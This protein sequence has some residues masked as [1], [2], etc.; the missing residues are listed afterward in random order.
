M[1]HLH[2]PRFLTLCSLLSNR[3]RDQISRYLTTL[4]ARNYATGSLKAVVTVLIRF[5]HALPPQRFICL[6]Q[7]FAQV[8]PADLD[9]LLVSAKANHLAPST[10]NNSVTLLRGFFEFLRDTGE[11]SR[12]PII[13]HRHPVFEPTTLPKPM[14]E[15]DLVAFFKAI[16]EVRDRSIFLL[17]LRCGLRI[18]E[19]CA[20]TW[21]VVDFSQGTLLIINGKGQVD[22]TAYLAPDVEQALRLWQHAQQPQSR[23]LFPGQYPQT[24][25][26]SCKSVS[27]RMAKYLREANVTRHYSPHCLRH[28]FA[29]QLINAGVTL[30]ALKELLGH[31]SLQ[32]TLCYTQLYEST[33]RQQYDQAMAQIERRQFGLGR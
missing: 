19:V 24:A 7:N 3:S 17:M 20:L 27:R 26:L 14:A 33:K 16:D 15:A 32:M 1:V 10:I 29:T 2:F 6:K 21:P 13:R 25:P 11:L 22:R 12:Q 18:S 9:A 8:I 28:T 5:L 30:E 31:R 4:F 23:F